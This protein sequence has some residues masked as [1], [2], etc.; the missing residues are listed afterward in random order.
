MLKSRLWL[1]IGIS[2]I[3]QA[4]LLLVPVARMLQA[5]LAAAL[6]AAMA[7]AAVFICT[8]I[9]SLISAL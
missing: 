5:E 8:V 7:K 4:N 9:K 3:L 1:V 2:V 6:A